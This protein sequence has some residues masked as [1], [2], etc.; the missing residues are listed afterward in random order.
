MLRRRTKAGWN[1]VLTHFDTILDLGDA[2][3]D[4]Y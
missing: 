3:G 4:N 2:D 1:I